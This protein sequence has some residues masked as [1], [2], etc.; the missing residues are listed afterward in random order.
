M[1]QLPFTPPSNNNFLYDPFSID[2]EN[3]F[4]NVTIED[5]VAD[6]KRHK[7]VLGDLE[8]K[9]RSKDGKFNFSNFMKCIE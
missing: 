1:S 7:N 9:F 6:G 4:D 3:P 2:F 5:L 8:A